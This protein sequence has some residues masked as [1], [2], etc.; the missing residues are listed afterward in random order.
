MQ[1]VYVPKIVF[2][3]VSILTTTFKFLLAFA[4]VLPVLW[5]S[6]RPVGL[7]YLALPPILVIEL[8]FIAAVAYVGAALVPFL[9]DLRILLDHSLR[10]LFFLSG[11][12][13]SGSLIPPRFRSYFYLNPMA[14]LIDAFRDVLLYDRW[15]PVG[16]LVAVG[17]VSGAGVFAG[18][19]LLTRYDYVYPKLGQ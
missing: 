12:F 1:R 10:L 16:S 19:Y 6:G 7:A 5:I 8:A 18:A 4:L 3:T 13:Y 11:V 14:T 17:L 15:P 2:P 9:P